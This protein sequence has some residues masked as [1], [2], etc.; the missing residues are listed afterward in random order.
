LPLR[1][2][3]EGATGASMPARQGAA[4]ARDKEEKKQAQNATG[5]KGEA[6]Q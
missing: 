1:R 6:A 3:E 4:E 5:G 2:V